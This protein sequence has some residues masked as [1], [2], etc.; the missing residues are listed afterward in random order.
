MPDGTAEQNMEPANPRKLLD[1][2]L[3]LA[4]FGV[5]GVATVVWLA[6]LAW[7]VRHP[8]RYLIAWLFG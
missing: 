1:W 2:L 8:I 7:L 3:P 5:A 6:V 4:Y